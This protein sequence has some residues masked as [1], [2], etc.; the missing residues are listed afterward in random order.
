V[1]KKDN[2]NTQ[3]KIIASLEFDLFRVQLKFAFRIRQLNTIFE[4]R[5]F[6]YLKSLVYFMLIKNTFAVSFASAAYRP[7][8]SLRGGVPP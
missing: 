1:Q 2:K 4:Q 3:T 6:F 5:F 7:V 8:P